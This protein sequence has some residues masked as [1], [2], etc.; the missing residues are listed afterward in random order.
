MSTRKEEEIKSPKDYL[1]QPKFSQL[2]VIF[3]LNRFWISRNCTLSP[4][5][6]F[7]LPMAGII[8]TGSAKCSL[9]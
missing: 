6:I 2:R 7:V 9:F 8:E 5:T 1:R 3:R 4:S